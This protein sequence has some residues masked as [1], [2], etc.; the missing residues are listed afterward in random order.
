MAPQAL[1]RFVISVNMVNPTAG[2]FEVMVMSWI[3]VLGYFLPQIGENTK[4][5]KL[6]R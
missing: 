5:V 6:T 3:R 1:A 2:S 4:A